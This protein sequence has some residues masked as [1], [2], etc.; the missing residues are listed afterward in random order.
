[1]DLP[2]LANSSLPVDVEQRYQLP[3]LLKP[4]YRNFDAKM[5]RAYLKD[6]F[7]SDVLE[8]A[9]RMEIMVDETYLRHCLVSILQH[10][11][12]RE[13]AD[14]PNELRQALYFN[15]RFS[16]QNLMRLERIREQ[17][18]SDCGRPFG[19]EEFHALVLELC[20]C[21]SCRLSCIILSAPVLQGSQAL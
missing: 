3:F 8:Q 14:T 21:D 18:V 6:E 17:L 10:F 9:G 15:W 13:G 1:M 11:H 2:R 16:N 12:K 20:L 7:H 4:H 5:L 19:R